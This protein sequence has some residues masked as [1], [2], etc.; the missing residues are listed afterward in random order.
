MY[1]DIPE[2]IRQASAKNHRPRLALALWGGATITAIA[3]TL[4]VWFM[5]QSRTPQVARPS[6]SVPNSTT[7]TPPSPNLLLGHF[8][9]PEAP[10]Q[11]LRPIVDDGS[12]KLRAA[13]AEQF[14]AMLTAAQ[15]EGINLV[16]I[17]GFRS[18][19]DQKHLFFD[20]KAERNQVTTER[21]QV[22]A[23]PG[24]SEHHTGYAIDMGDA[25]QPETNLSP[26]FDTTQ[27]F[28]W[29]QTNAA[30]YS[31]ELSFP[32][33]NP[34][35]VSYEPW[36]WRFV[37]DQLSLETFYKARTTNPENGTSP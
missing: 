31:F 19:A 30:R 6:T 11:E 14:R 5:A 3:L 28:K 16:P 22:S 34:Q 17:S 29:L 9:Y 32:K 35:G 10:P 8:S 13:A 2:A 23:P 26:S 36:H 1:E 20:V 12:I 27:S 24:H 21:A 15:A 7:T 18:I 37:G 4:G 25:S 33:D